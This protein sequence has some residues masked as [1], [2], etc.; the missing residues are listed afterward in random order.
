MHDIIESTQVQQYMQNSGSLL[1]YI[2]QIIIHCIAGSTDTLLGEKQAL[3]EF[4][5]ALRARLKF[6]DE[7]ELAANQFAAAAAAPD[8]A[9]LMPL[10]NRLDD[11]IA[12]V[13]A[14]PQYADAVAY[15]SKFRQLHSRALGLVR[16]RV[17]TILR[18]AAQTVQA[19]VTEAAGQS[20]GTAG[21]QGLPARAASGQLQPAVS[22]N[23]SLG[24]S[25]PVLQEGMEVSILYVRFRAVAEPVLKGE[26][27]DTLDSL[28]AFDCYLNVPSSAWCSGQCSFCSVFCI[29]PC[30]Y[31]LSA[32]M[33]HCLNHLAST[34][35]IALLYQ[36][37]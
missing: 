25:G 7:Y 12:Y 10:L 27:P 3:L 24:R 4:A 30:H 32:V 17:Q 13:A 2:A 31:V 11:C 26:A 33:N 8:N 9:E 23:S 14:N 6:F 21:Q 1:P 29:N 22:R 28:T 15:A 5:E 19:A 35:P 36:E 34:L 37:I 18:Q 20:D 16:G